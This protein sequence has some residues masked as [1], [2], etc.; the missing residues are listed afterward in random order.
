V[1]CSYWNKLGCEPCINNGLVFL[2]AHLSV[3]MVRLTAIYIDQIV[4][5]CLWKW[6]KHHDTDL[7][8]V[9]F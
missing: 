5:M 1:L 2:F 6:K 9:F 4:A 8:S 3:M 7:N